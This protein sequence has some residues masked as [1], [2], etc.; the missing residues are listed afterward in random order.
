MKFVHRL[1]VSVAVIVVVAVALVMYTGG[2]GHSS[3]YEY[4]SILVPGCSACTDISSFYTLLSTYN[5]SLS[6]AYSLGSKYGNSLIENYSVANLPS[7][8]MSATNASA[9]IFYGLIY[10]NVFNL[11]GNSLILN[12]PFTAGLYRNVTFYDIIQNK[13]IESLDIYNQS[14]VYNISSKPSYETYINPSQFLLLS[15]S[16][17]IS[18]GNKTVIDFIYGDSPFSALQTIVL[19]TALSSFGNF[20]DYS[21]MRSTSVAFS[22]G[23]VIGPV[24]SY[25]LTAAY[26]SSNYFSLRIYNVSSPATVADTSVQRE[27]FEFDQNALSPAFGNVGNFLPFLNIG[28]RYISVSSMLNPFYFSNMQ[29]SKFY[30]E[31]RTNSTLGSMFNDSVAFAQAVLCS[32]I[33]NS[34]SICSTPLVEYE[35]NAIYKDLLT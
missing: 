17:P 2:K 12:T 7:V 26:Y 6:K 8:V 16:S 10:L 30:S 28:G 18:S 33:A 5:F 3:G 14:D 19:F 1:A 15:N 22:Q 25:N 21:T 13:T 24:Y 23:E 35:T 11:V 32:D 20:S 27:L 9:N 31:M 29:L 34:A 4:T